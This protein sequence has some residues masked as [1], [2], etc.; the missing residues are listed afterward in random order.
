M[1]MSESLLAS[2]EFDRATSESI[3]ASVVE[4]VGAVEGVRPTDL[5]PLQATV[6]CDA[7]ERVVRSDGFAGTVGF[8]YHGYRVVVD[9]AGEV[10]VR[11]DDRSVSAP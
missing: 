3:C 6:D 1:V 5:D 2:T 4:A 9:G 10:E 7:L 11:A 8:D